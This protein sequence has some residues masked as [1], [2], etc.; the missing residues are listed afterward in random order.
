V[1]RLTNGAWIHGA[2]F[3]EG[4][5][6]GIG[7]AGGSIALIDVASKALCELWAHGNDSGLA[8]LGVA[9]EQGLAVE[10]DIAEI[11]S[12]DLANAEANP[13][14][15]REYGFVD[16]GTARPLGPIGQSTGDIE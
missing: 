12:G 11:Q 14:E 4:E 2:T 15:Q 9:D 5:Q 13:I 7:V 10:V 3:G 6:R 1:K 16:E 8:E